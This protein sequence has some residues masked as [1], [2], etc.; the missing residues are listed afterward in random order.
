MLKVLDIFFTVFHTILILFNLF[1]WLSK[2]FA[3]LNFFTLIL[4]FLSWTVLGIFYGLGYCPF[5]DWHWDILRQ[6]G[7]SNLPSSYIQFLI[8]RFT[9]WLPPAEIIDIFTVAGL[10]LALGASVYV[11]FFK[12]KR[13]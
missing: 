5:T 4:T 12:N 11:N 10:V 3:R 13:K 7:Y 9:G 8:S 2:R 6:L 1:G